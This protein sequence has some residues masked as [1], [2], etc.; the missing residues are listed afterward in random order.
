MDLFLYT[1]TMWTLALETTSSHGSVA[2]L[3]H[4]SVAASSLLAGRHYASALFHAVNEILSECSLGLDDI[5]LF[6]VADG[7]GSFTGVRIGLTAVKGWTEVLAK[8]AVAV[9]TLRA[10]AGATSAPVLAVVDAARNEVYAGWYPHGTL[11]VQAEEG[12]SATVPQSREWLE[13]MATF[14]REWEG[15]S[16]A[17]R[18]RAV[19]PDPALRTT[20]SWLEQGEAEL[21]PAVGLLGRSDFLAGHAQNGLQL[22]ARY[23][24]RSDAEMAQLPQP[25]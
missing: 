16:K 15:R 1:E 14:R 25:A 5:G 6:A 7:P 4:G 24:R 20:C 21:A 11:A 22:D 12:G 8:P 19:S 13:G 3:Q 17:Q 23:I 10:I 2:L 18:F 9:S